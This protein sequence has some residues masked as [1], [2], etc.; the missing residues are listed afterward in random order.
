MNKF[1]GFGGR[2]YHH[3]RIHHPA[4]KFS[5]QSRIRA[6]SDAILEFFP[7]GVEKLLDIG[8]ADGLFARGIKEAIPKIQKV[9]G[10]DIQND[11]LVYNPFFSAQGSCT[12]MPFG[13]DTFDLITA[14]ALI[15][16][17]P[18]PGPFLMECHRVL[19]PGG[20]LFLTCPAPFFEWMATKLGYLKHAGHLA[21]YDLSDIKR[22]C[23]NAG[24]N[25]VLLKRF[26]I[27][28][29]NIPGHVYLESFFQT[30]GSSFLMLNQVVGSIKSNHK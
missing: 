18:E 28:P 9:Y 1:K 6:V 16:H 26:M 27:T 7:G 8:T 23:E 25:V 2:D 29:I 19:K 20:G 12:Q 10:L 3:T 21:R 24:F 11:Q 4:V 17:L 13:D 15:E 22:L 14:A 5:L 30:I